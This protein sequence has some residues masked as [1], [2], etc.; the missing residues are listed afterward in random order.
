[1]AKV[2]ITVTESNCRGGC[3]KAGDTYI[4]EDLCP[5]VCH[6]LWNNI[7]PSVYALING[8]V[9][10][11][12]DG[13]TTAFTASCPD[14]GRVKIHAELAEDIKYPEI[15]CTKDGLFYKSDEICMM[16]PKRMP[17]GFIKTFVP[18]DIMPDM[19]ESANFGKEYGCL[20]YMSLED[21]RKIV[22]CGD[23]WYLLK[24]GQ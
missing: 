17:D 11:F 23:T 24:P 5:P 9:L 4:V 2:K 18:A 1:M 16:V 3:M 8:A 21:G 20:E 15:V 6:E 19:P 13:K 14:G 22:K 7:Y 12:G 10:D